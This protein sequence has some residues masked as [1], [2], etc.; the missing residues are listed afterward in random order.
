MKTNIQ[1]IQGAWDLG[2]S[3]DKHTLNSEFTGYNE[4]GHPTFNTTR[5]DTGE[6]LYQL[7]YR[8]RFENVPVLGEQLFVSLSRAFTSASFIV[9]M[10][11]SKQRLRQPVV[12]LSRDL[13]SRMNIPC[14]E[15]LL[16]KNQSTAP[17]KDIV[18]RVQKIQALK[19]A[20]S[21]NDVLDTG[22]YDVLIVDDLFDSGSSLEAATYTLRGYAKVRNVFAV[23]VT[24][25]HDN[26]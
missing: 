4:Q 21:I 7:K 15:N 18:D 19:A 9:P 12:E 3:L 26:G 22:L 1:R 8:N 14:I 10:P 13:A 2:F 25:K 5:S 16:L 11:P 24:R 6:A 23:T 17:M 20:F